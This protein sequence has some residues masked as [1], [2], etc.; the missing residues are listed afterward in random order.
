MTEFQDKRISLEANEDLSRKIENLTSELVI[1][2]DKAQKNPE[3]KNSPHKAESAPMLKT[4]NHNKPFAPIKVS[5]VQSVVDKV[6]KAPLKSQPKPIV[7]SPSQVPETPDKIDKISK[8]RKLSNQLKSTLRLSRQDESDFHDD[9]FPVG[10]RRGQK[11]AKSCEVWLDHKPQLFAKL[12]KHFK[13]SKSLKIIPLIINVYT[14]D[15]I[16]QPIIHRK[17]SVKKLE[18]KDTKST[19]KYVLTHQ[20]QDDYGEVVTS[21][22]KVFSLVKVPLRLAEI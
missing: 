22:I 15:T 14:K 3:R 6:E 8:T 7:T 19:S 9:G 16:M 17:R 5:S 21:L 10:G 12:G 20:H 2:L 11:R 13:P 1:I 4:H 18:F